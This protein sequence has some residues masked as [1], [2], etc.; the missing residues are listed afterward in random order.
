MASVYINGCL[1][2]PLI[3][4]SFCNEL[5]L[6]DHLSLGFYSTRLLPQRLVAKIHDV[7]R[8]KI[9]ILSPARYIFVPRGINMNLNIHRR[10]W[11]ILIIS[12]KG[13]QVNMKE[14]LIF[15]GALVENEQYC[16]PGERAFAVRNLNIFCRISVAVNWLCHMWSGT[17]KTGFPMAMLLFIIIIPAC[18]L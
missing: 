16:Q 8:M 15:H 7:F 18:L 6:S 3:L 17:P 2:K 5:S 11:K 13:H 12:L 4:K 1:S 14:V 9:V 10:S